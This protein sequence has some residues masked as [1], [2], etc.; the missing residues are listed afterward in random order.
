RNDRT[1]PAQ[2][3]QRLAAHWPASNPRALN[4]GVPGYNTAQELALLE[5]RVL[6]FEPDVVILQ[7]TINDLHVCNYLWPRFPTLNTLIH[8]SHFAVFAVKQLLYSP[9]GV[10]HLYD[11]VGR[12]FP[13]L[14]LFQP[15]LVGTLRALPEGDERLRGHPPRSPERVPERYHYML[16]RENWERHLRRFGALARGAGATLL[17]TGFIEAEDRAVWERAGFEVLSFYEIFEGRDMR[18]EGG[19]D[20]S[21]TAD[22]FSARGSQIIGTALADAILR[23]FGQPPRAR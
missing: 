17:G 1:I 2:I 8:K 23:R 19:Y 16:G 9:F 20:P 21:R 4:F 14:L 13:D 7:Y 5:A 6:A 22:H 15:G 3:E 18:A 12:I 11:P 10:R